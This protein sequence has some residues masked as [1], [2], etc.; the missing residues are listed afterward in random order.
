MAI[1]AIRESD[2]VI[3]ISRSRKLG[4]SLNTIRD[5]MQLGERSSCC[6]QVRAVTVAH[7]NNVRQQIDALRKIEQVLNG[8]VD[9]C[10]RRAAPHCP[11]L[12]ELKAGK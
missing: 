12:D 4:F 5:L 10:A 1:A 6:D 2:A 7:R 9:K 11:I 8:H 3:F